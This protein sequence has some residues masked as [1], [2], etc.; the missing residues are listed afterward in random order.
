M[1]PIVVAEDL[2]MLQEFIGPDH[3]FKG[4]TADKVIVNSVYF[5]TTRRTGGVR[6]RENQIV[7]VGQQAMNQRGL[8]RARRRG[9]DI[10]PSSPE[11]AHSQPG[12]FPTEASSFKPA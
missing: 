2:G 10:N 6:D 1:R 8:S 9:D 5:L 11:P 7:M 4:H 12:P 3:L